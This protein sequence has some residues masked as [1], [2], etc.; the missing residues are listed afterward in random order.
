MVDTIVQNK[1]NLIPTCEFGN[2]I[3][4]WNI[5][6]RLDIIYNETN[7]QYFR[8]NQSRYNFM[9]IYWIFIQQEKL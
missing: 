2:Y 3:L 6:D 7:I 4:D 9:N 8:I 5:I 1:A